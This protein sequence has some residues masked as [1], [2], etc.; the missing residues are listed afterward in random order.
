MSHQ[1]LKEGFQGA[2]LKSSFERRNVLQKKTDKFL[3]KIVKKDY[4]NE[5]EKVLEKK[6]FDENTKSMLLSILYKIETAYRDYEKVK[7]DV[8]EKEDFIQSIIRNIKN[9]CE[10]IKIV[11]LNSKESEMLGNKTFLVEKSKKRIICYPIERKLLYCIAK[12]NRNEKIIKNKYYIIDRTLSD[13][14]NVGK[15]I[16]TVEPIRDFNGYSWTTI[17]REI[18]SIYHNLVY[19]NIRILVGNKFLNKWIENKEF[20][21]DYLESFK[22]KLQEQYGEKRQEELIENLNII[23]VLLTARYNK[24]IKAKLEKEKKEVENKLEKIK[25][26]QKFVQE[27]TK[28]KRELTKKIKQMDETLNNKTMLQKEYEKRNEFLPLEEKIFSVRILSQM[29]AEEREEKLERL[30]KL[31]LLLNPQK[32]MELK[33][34]LEIKE[35]YLKQI[36]SKDIEEQ[37]KH[38]ILELQKIFL[39]CYQIKVRKAETKQELMKLIYEFRYYCLLPVNDRKAIYQ[40]EEIEK[41]R[42]EV[43]TMLIEKAH[44]FKLIDTFSKEKEIV[45]QILKN[46][47]YVRVINLEDLYFKLIKEKEAYY[48]QLFDENVFEEKIKLEGIENI[49]KE[50]LTFKMNKKIK[51]FD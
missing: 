3:D 13:V 27:I 29:M 31:N 17:P 36:D 14:I 35:S 11:K 23:S 32:F 50:D 15:N 40:V 48:V 45:Y 30:E 6:A 43:Q 51:I 4:N 28:E 18:E 21:I 44:E 2:S 22:D 49:K 38:R 5:L 20:I 39:E 34:E 47:F 41:E 46:I 16:D 1:S 26:N 24:K 25:D 42:K 33:K 10:T 12:I 19:Q 8:E 7:P 37:I 9:N